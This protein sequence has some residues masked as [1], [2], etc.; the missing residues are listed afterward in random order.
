MK[1]IYAGSRFKLLNKKCEFVSFIAVV[2]AWIQLYYCIFLNFWKP[3]LTYFRK[4]LTSAEFLCNRF[5]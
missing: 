3:L 1:F 4:K 5:P 2:V